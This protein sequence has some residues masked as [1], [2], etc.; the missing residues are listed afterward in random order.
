[1]FCE[2][3]LECIPFLIDPV[4]SFHIGIEISEYNTVARYP[5]T[6]AQTKLGVVTSTEAGPQTNTAR[7]KEDPRNK[8]TNREI[9][10][11]RRRKA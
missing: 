11:H 6:G 2:P 3:D 4:A 8:K 7:V 1:M 9:V 5:D 10:K